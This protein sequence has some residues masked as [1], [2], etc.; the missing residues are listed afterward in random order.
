MKEFIFIF[1]IY[2]T[3][4]SNN[5]NFTSTENINRDLQDRYNL[6][7]CKSL[8]LTGDVESEFIKSSD[9][10]TFTAFKIDF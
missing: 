5:I 4:V 3:P 7:L 10:R 8:V 6:K 2:T 1:T 9:H